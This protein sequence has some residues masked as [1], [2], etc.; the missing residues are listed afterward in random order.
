MLS[1]EKMV[2]FVSC[3]LK[4]TSDLYLNET[5]PSNLAVAERC[6]ENLVMHKA[7]IIETLVL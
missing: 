7:S 1:N 4:L 2:S 6:S 5:N 3:K